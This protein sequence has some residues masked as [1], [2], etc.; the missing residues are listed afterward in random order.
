MWS[1]IAASVVDLPEP[2][3]PVTSTSPRGNSAMLRNTAGAL[4]SSSDLM[5]VGMV[6]ITAPVPRFS[7]SAF[8]RK[9][10]SPGTSKEKSHSRLSSNTLRCLSFMMS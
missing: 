6:R 10:A 1:I 5:R 7:T 4:S 8:T 3:G 2:V 9:R